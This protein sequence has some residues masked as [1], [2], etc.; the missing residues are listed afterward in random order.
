MAARQEVRRCLEAVGLASSHIVEGQPPHRR[1]RRNAGGVGSP[2]RPWHNRPE[3]RARILWVE[4]YACFH[5]K[6]HFRLPVGGWATRFLPATAGD[7]EGDV[8]PVVDKPLI[9]EVVE[10]ACAVGIEELIFVTGCGKTAIERPL[11]YSYELQDTLEHRAQRRKRRWTWSPTRCRRWP[12]R[13]YPPKRKPRG[14]GH[15]VWCAQPGR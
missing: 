9:H 6:S 3:P 5:R 13:L 1:E 7:A 10:D 12:G 8:L 11:H 2:V 14:L 15:A 4:Y